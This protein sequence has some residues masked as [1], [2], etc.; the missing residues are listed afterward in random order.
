M[1]VVPIC[2]EMLAGLGAPREPIELVRTADGVRVVGVRSRIDRT[3]AIERVAR[4]IGRSPID[5]LVL[6]RGS[7]SCEPND[8]RVRGGGTEPGRFAAIVRAARPGLPCADEVELDDP[9]ALRRFIA[10]VQ[11]R[12]D[13]TAGS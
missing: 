8:V 3:D 1:T 9:A 11:R 2:P 5:G 4:R 13:P 7:P 12:P 6:K 10:A